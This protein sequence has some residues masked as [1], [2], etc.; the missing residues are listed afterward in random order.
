MESVHLPIVPLTACLG[1]QKVSV[2]LRLATLKTIQIPIYLSTIAFCNKAAPPVEAILPDSGVPISCGLK[3]P[4]LVHY[5]AI[6]SRKK[7]HPTCAATHLL[8]EEK[9]P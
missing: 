3:S 1:L 9:D 4:L 7:R 2:C 8:I 5:N 6:P